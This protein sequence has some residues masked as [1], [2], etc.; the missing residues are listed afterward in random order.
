L[1]IK[2]KKVFVNVSKAPKAARRMV[3]KQRE[4]LEDPKK[5]K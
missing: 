1:W 4:E 3:N 2:A 5:V